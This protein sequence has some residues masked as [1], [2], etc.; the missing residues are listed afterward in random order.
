MLEKK[1]NYCHD[2]LTRE[3]QKRK[4]KNRSYSLRAFARDLDLNKTSLGEVLAN[5]RLLSLKNLQKIIKSMDLTLVEK[6]RLHDEIKQQK[7]EPRFSTSG[8]QLTSS[9]I[10]ASKQ[11]I[12]TLLTEN[13]TKHSVPS[14]IGSL[15]SKDN[16]SS[17]H[18]VNPV[19][20]SI[21]CAPKESIEDLLDRLKSAFREISSKAANSSWTVNVSIQAQQPRSE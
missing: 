2:L 3:F 17:T 14:S 9:Q 18:L 8:S 20:L 12:E 10:A 13:F 16:F 4:R 21:K 1:S 5:R 19:Q 7:N 15:S 11:S 6:K